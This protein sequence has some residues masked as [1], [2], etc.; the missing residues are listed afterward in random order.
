M[1]NYDVNLEHMQDQLFKTLQPE[2]IAKAIEAH[3]YSSF[4]HNR[5]S[6]D[7][8]VLKAIANSPG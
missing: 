3:N 7:A 5:R 1:K 4:Q 8:D 6:I 2:V